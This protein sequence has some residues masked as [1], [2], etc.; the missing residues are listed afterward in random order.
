MLELEPHVRG[1][2]MDSPAAGDRVHNPESPTSHA[3][4]IALSHGAL[5]PL[6]LVDHLDEQAVLVELRAQNDLAAPVN[7]GIGY[8]LTGQQLGVLELR[9]SDVRQPL[10]EQTTGDPGRMHTARQARLEPRRRHVSP[11]RPEKCA[12]T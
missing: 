5:E 9:A 10:P 4:K 11:R 12:E 7:E 8:E 3:L 1:A 6:A 2:L